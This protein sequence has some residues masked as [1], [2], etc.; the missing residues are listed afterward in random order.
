[1]PARINRLNA[2]ITRATEDQTVTRDEVRAMITEVGSNRSVSGT[3]RAALLKAL[4]DHGSFIAFDSEGRARAASRF[5]VA[6]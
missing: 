1:M 4:S 5:P 3:E 2:L 6:T